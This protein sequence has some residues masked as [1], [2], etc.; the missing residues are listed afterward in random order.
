M[1][2]LTLM[3]L[4]MY[5][6]RHEFYKTTTTE[7]VDIL[8]NFS[9]EAIT[10]SFYKFEGVKLDIDAIREKALNIP[11]SIAMKFISLVKD[12]EMRECIRAY[13]L[14]YEL[15]NLNTLLR[16]RLNGN[17]ERDLFLFGYSTVSTKEELL[18]LVKI[19][20]IRKVYLETISYH[21]IRSKRFREVVRN[22]SLD[23]IN[24]LLVYSSVEYYKNLISKKVVF[25]RSFE[26]LV[27]VKA[28]YE[29]LLMLAKMKFLA[30]IDVEKYLVELY[31]LGGLEEKL[32]GILSSTKEGLIKRC[33]DYGALPPNFILT[34]IDDI[35]RFKN[36]I[37]K[38]RCREII[39][40]T[41]MD[42][43]AVIAAIVLREIDMKNYLSVIGGFMSGFS[44]EK[45][46]Q[47]LVL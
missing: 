31:F 7:M 3:S 14:F 39:V 19:D 40:G 41:P 2:T 33:I 38:M 17:T 10:E 32:V 27:R 9:S 26:S 5:P 43:A 28:F 35:D 16:A 20:D 45:V 46:R 24:E 42:P 12:S 44:F 11:V 34:D 15:Y 13:M 36:V 8:S 18:N 29:I 22:V 25:G 4:L 21:R 37:L 47:F 30:G 6:I 23:S 1:D